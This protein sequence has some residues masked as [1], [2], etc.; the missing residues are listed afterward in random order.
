MLAVRHYIH[1]QDTLW[2]TTTDSI[3]NSAGNS[4][5]VKHDTSEFIRPTFTRAY[6]VFNAQDSIGWALPYTYLANTLGDNLRP[7]NAN[8]VGK[9]SY[10]AEYTT[11]LAFVDGVHM[12]DTFYV[13]RGKIENEDIDTTFLYKI[14]QRDKHY[15]GENTHYVPRWNRNGTIGDYNGKSMVFQFRLIDPQADLTRSFLIE[16]QT[17]ESQ[18]G[19]SVAR[20]V[21]IQNGVPVVSFDIDWAVATQNGAEIFN[22]LEGITDKAVANEA[23]PVVGAAKVI[24][25][26]GAVTI[27]NAAGK[28]VAVSNILG[29][30]V[31]NA[32][33]TSD[34]ATISLPKGIVVVAIEGEPAVKAIVK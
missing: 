31:A 26:V 8:Y 23:A 4:W 10:G 18:M 30:T 16:S 29:Q 24:G 19:P 25:E 15:L 11:R 20:W 5:I 2:K 21:K 3:W 22:V 14:P 33:L 1:L 6:W 28:K 9:F 27:Q 32:V 12:T 13:L 7:H 17:E 34:N